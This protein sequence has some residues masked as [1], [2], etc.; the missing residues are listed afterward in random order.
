VVPGKGVA[1]EVEAVVEEPVRV[2]LIPSSDYLGHP[3]PQRHNH[4]FERVHDG[5]EFEVHVVRFDIFGKPKLATR[6]IVHEIP[7]ELRIGKTGL[8]YLANVFSYTH[9]ILRIVREESIDVVFAGN[10]LPPL[11]YEVIKRLMER[12]IPTVFDLQDYYPTSATGYLADVKSVAGSML[13]GLFEAMTRFLIRSASIVAV[14]G[15]ALAMYSRRVGARKVYIVPNGISEHFLERYSGEE[16]R[17]RLGFG[18]EDFVV[19][20]VGSIEFWLDMEPLIKGVAMARERGLTVKLLLIGKQ[21]QSGYPQKVR[22]WLEMYRVEDATTWLDFVPHTDVPK[23]VAAMDLATIPFDVE[24]PTAF[25]AA[26][27][28]LWEYLSQ[29]TPVATTPI[30]EIIAYKHIKKV[31]IVRTAQDYAKAI[32]L[33]GKDREKVVHPEVNQMLKTRLWQNSTQKLKQIL[34]SLYKDR[35][36]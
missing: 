18:D 11:T 26:P 19:G 7:L 3:F 9:E 1:I 20:Y 23:Y 12:R 35:K 32:E 8:Y 22:K 27:N 21:L 33:A 24:N 31:Y 14:P 17:K 25:Y 29:G 6:C 28:K 34:K 30:P 4:L 10:L 2:L 5:R 36:Q 13:K 15:I 16:V